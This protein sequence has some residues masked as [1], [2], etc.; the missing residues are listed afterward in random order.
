[1][2][3][4]VC[5]VTH[6]EVGGQLVEAG[7]LLSPCGLQALNSGLWDWQH[8]PFPAEPSQWSYYEFLKVYFYPVIYY[9]INISLNSLSKHVTV[10]FLSFIAKVMICFLFFFFFVGQSMAYIL[11]VTLVLAT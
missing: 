9:N 5:V 1:M 10:F 7:S 4:H 6:V 11:C 3:T 8:V 2:H